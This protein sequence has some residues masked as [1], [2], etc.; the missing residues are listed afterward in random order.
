MSSTLNSP[1][2]NDS[3]AA[4]RPTDDRQRLIALLARILARHWLNRSRRG[5]RQAGHPETRRIDPPPA[6]SRR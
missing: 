3:S 2:P 6:R 4:E 1:T 5:T